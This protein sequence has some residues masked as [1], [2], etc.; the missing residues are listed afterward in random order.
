M[1]F[2]YA[3]DFIIEGLN[4]LFLEAGHVGGEVETGVPKQSNVIEVGRRP[5]NEFWGGRLVGMPRLSG[6]CIEVIQLHDLLGDIGFVPNGHFMNKY[7]KVY[8]HL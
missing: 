5:I 1:F 6:P 3:V 2:H 7:N 8:H 4:V